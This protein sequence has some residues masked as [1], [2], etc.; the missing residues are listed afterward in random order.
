MCQSCEVLYI[1]GVKTHEIGCP[2]AWKDYKRECAW[3]GQ[4]FLPED[5][6]QECCSDECA[7]SYR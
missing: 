6:R 7:E 3:C 1:N 4:K 5:R 2:E